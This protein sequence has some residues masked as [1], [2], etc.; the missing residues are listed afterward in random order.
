M[1]EYQAH[2]ILVYDKAS[3]D[4]D[5]LVQ[6]L[7]DSAFA[8]TLIGNAEEAFQ[9]CLIDHPDLVIF[10]IKN[11]GK[12]S[13]EFFRQVKNQYSTHRIPVMLTTLETDYKKR[14][15]FL[16][17]KVDDFVAKPY[18][19]EEVAA[20]VISL[21][22]EFKPTTLVAKPV[23]RGFWGS[24]R[25]MNLIDLIQTMELG[26]KSGIIHL[27]RGDKEG[28]IYV[29]KGKIVNAVVEAYD[30]VERA[31][32]HMLTWI[33]GTFHVVFQEIEVTT[34]LKEDNESFFREGAKVIDQWRRVIGELPSLH[35]C[36]A[37][38]ST[39]D[40]PVLSYSERA[41]L[42][43]FQKPKNILQ[44]IDVSDFDDFDGLQ[45]IK[46]LLEKGLLIKTDAR[47]SDDGSLPSTFRPVLDR[48]HRD[49]K[50]AYSH[51][52]SIFQRNKKQDKHSGFQLSMNDIDD[53]KMAAK[54]RIANNIQ[55]TKAELLLIRQKLG[56]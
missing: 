46:S 26:K 18:Y 1:N 11:E 36:L 47:Q 48:R 21:F 15:E 22:Q 38:V 54:S 25:E 24:L 17:M 16:E 23:D 42:S 39:E 28:Q 29:N 37:A 27:N 6:L 30:S 5:R 40:A 41:M 13:E 4:V 53:E 3:T 50:S 35:M 49:A 9:F 51:I 31:Y 32:L 10:D 56:R 44:A 33:E 45:V 34:P 52:F 14:V 7:T 43:Q 55:L 19:P 12:E 2:R 20:R 8:V